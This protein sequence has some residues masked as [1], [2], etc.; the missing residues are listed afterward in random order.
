[1]TKKAFQGTGTAMVTPFTREGAIDEPALRRFV[2]FQ[3]EGGVDM[4]LPGGTTGEGAT[5]EDDEADR[6]LSIVLDQ[7][8]GRVPVIFGAGSN[9]T[10]KAVKATERAK[11]LGAAGVLSVGPYYNKPTQGGYIEHFRAVAEV[12]LPVVVYN[13]PGRTGSNILASTTLKL[14]EVPNIVAV[15][16]ASGD[17]GQMMEIIR[18]RPPEFRVLSGDDAI[19]LPLIAAGGDGIVS[20]VSNEVPGM[21]SAMTNA[22]LAGD[23]GSARDLHYKMLPLMNANFVESNPIPAK[24]VLAMMGLMGE[25]YRLPLV[26]ITPGNR[27]NLQKIADSLGLIQSVGAGRN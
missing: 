26:P 19:T 3:I 24:A 6:L 7:A 20:V 13:V 15:K 10:K 18:S 4:L 16:E 12:G 25:N 2:D 9:S 1:M 23:Y 22:A 27:V 21:M 5:L 14:A 11:K 17:L 8:K